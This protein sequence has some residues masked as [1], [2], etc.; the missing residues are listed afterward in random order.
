V[1]GLLGRTDGRIRGLF[2]RNPNTK[3]HRKNKSSISDLIHAAMRS[4]DLEPIAEDF[5]RTAS[6]VK[7]SWIEELEEMDQG[8]GSG[9]FDMTATR[10]LAVIPDDMLDLGV[11]VQWLTSSTRRIMPRVEELGPEEELEVERLELGEEKPASKEEPSGTLILNLSLLLVAVF[12]HSSNSTALHMLNGVSPTMKLFWRMSASYLILVPFAIVYVRRKGFPTLS[13][14]GWTTFVSAAAFYTCSTLSFYTALEYTTIGNAV[15][16]A[17]SQALLLIVGKVFIGEPIH[18][19]EAIGVVVAFSGAILCSK[20]SEESSEELDTTNALFG[21]LLALCSA[22]FGVAYLT[23]ARVVRSHMSVMFFITFVMFLGSLMVL[24]FLAISP[25]EEVSFDMDPF[26]GIFGGFNVSHHRLEVLAYLAIVVNIGG[27][28]GMIRAMQH[29][30]TIIIAV[31][32]LMEPLAASLIAFVCKAGLLPGPLGWLGN[33]LVVLGTL[34][35]VY[36]SMG[37]TDSGGMH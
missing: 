12:A 1:E 14:S 13:F 15:I 28:M 18:V 10:S 37:K 2:G 4:V 16:Y 27:S 22:A 24:A 17:N 32:T 11:E 5:R 33:F 21:D 8:V 34:G 6:S 36:P 23:V 35:V 31:A 30:D 7:D 20:D 3:R 29:F 26:H 19:F 9:F 25:H